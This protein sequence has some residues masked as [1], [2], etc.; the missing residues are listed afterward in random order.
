MR[1]RSENLRPGVLSRVSPQRDGPEKGE[2]M[3]LGPQGQHGMN[4]NLGVS[5][6]L[7]GAGPQRVGPETTARDG[8]PPPPTVPGTGSW[9]SSCPAFWGLQEGGGAGRRGWGWGGGSVGGQLPGAPSD[10]SSLGSNGHPW[11]PPS[12]RPGR[13]WDP[14]HLPPCVLWPHGPHTHA[15]L[16]AAPWGPRV[17]KFQDPGREG[18]GRAA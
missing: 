12:C 17:E 2:Q 18:G 13:V 14:V 16:P 9:P 6:R 15:A 11:S 1:V 5:V 8:D 3:P 4:S 7:P 10:L